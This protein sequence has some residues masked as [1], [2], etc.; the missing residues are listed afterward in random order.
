MFE[1]DGQMRKD[2]KD[3]GFLSPKVRTKDSP[4]NRVCE[5]MLVLDDE[6]HG[7]ADGEVA[8]KRKPGNKR[9]FLRTLSEGSD[10]SGGTQEDCGQS[11][12]NLGRFMLDNVQIFDDD[13]VRE[14]MVAVIVVFLS[15]IPF[16]NFWPGL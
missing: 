5:P 13:F 6:A 7:A 2:L 4:K 15:S 9:T 3:L 12:L 8:T 10:R 14:V 1:L 16:L 11:S